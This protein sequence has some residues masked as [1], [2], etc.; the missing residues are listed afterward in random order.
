MHYNYLEDY[1]NECKLKVNVQ[2]TKV[3]MFQNKKKCNVQNIVFLYERKQL[4]IVHEFK[5]LSIVNFNGRF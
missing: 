5:Y 3:K 4:D 2:K 1:C